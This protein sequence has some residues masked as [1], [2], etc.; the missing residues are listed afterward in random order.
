MACINAVCW[1]LLSPPFQVP[2]EPAHFAYVQQLA[3]AHRL[4]TSAGERY[5]PAEMGALADLRHGFVQ[6][7]PSEGTI[8]TPA[9]QRK[10]DAR[11]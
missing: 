5:S 7:V 2:E 1:S 10:L 4:P 3:E 6:F 11:P 9:Q 8:S